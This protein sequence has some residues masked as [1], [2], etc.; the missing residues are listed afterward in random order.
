MVQKTEKLT[1]AANI[2]IPPTIVE[3]MEAVAETSNSRDNEQPVL[4]LEEQQ[5]TNHQP[6]PALEAD[7]G[8][9]GDAGGYPINDFDNED[10]RSGAYICLNTPPPIPLK[11]KSFSLSL[12]LLSIFFNNLG[13]RKIHQFWR[14]I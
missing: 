8:G 6:P 7:G 14:E 10:L 9:G 12:T 1:D 3:D 13:K 2:N 5:D 4:L 11:K